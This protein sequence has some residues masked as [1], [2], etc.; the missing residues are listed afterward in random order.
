MFPLATPWRV[1]F[2][3]CLHVLCDI[4]WWWWCTEGVLYGPLH[5]SVAVEKFEQ[6]VEEA[7]AEGGV[8]ECGGKVQES[9]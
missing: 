2:Q 9:L 5:N 4:W 7:K 8:V 1:S 3:F 6:A